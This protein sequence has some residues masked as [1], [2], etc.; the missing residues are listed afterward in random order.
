[1]KRELLTLLPQPL[2]RLFVSD[3]LHLLGAAKPGDRIDQGSFNHLGITGSLQDGT[4]LMNDLFLIGNR[5]S[6]EE[7][8]G[9]PSGPAHRALLG[10]NETLDS[11]TRYVHE[12]E[13]LAYLL[14]DLRKARSARSLHPLASEQLVHALAL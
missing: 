9:S 4:Q 6:A 10:L 12:P 7:P 8:L 13:Q 11:G 2:D 5:R 1:M 3:Q 14:P